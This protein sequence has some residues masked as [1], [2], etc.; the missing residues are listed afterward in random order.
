MSFLITSV[1]THD[2]S[3]HDDCD[4]H[5]PVHLRKLFIHGLEV[6][7]DHGLGVLLVVV[8]RRGGGEVK[9]CT[10]RR[11]GRGAAALVHRS[12]YACG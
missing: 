4:S 12:Q 10:R 9:V 11:E 7:L 5:D 8:A 1:A 6:E 3:V 2:G